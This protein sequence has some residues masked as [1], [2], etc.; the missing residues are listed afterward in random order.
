MDEEVVCP[1]KTVLV[2]INI[3]EMK[4]F[5]IVVR[6]IFTRSVRWLTYNL[7]IGGIKFLLSAYC[8]WLGGLLY[9]LFTSINIQNVTRIVNQDPVKAN[10]VKPVNTDTLLSLH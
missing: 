7:P 2:M 4:T 5:I 3:V 8:S 10:P 1:R 9:L 6:L